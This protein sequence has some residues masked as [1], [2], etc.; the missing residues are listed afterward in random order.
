[1]FPTMPT[2]KRCRRYV[3]IDETKLKKNGIRIYV[4]SSMDIDNYNILAIR[5]SITDSMDSHTLK[6]LLKVW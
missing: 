6:T 5:V 2:R 4:W 1:M 3:A